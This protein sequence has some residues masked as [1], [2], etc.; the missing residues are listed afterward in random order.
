MIKDVIAD[1]LNK[2]SF[3]PQREAGEAFAPTNIALIKYWGKRDHQLNLPVT[4]SLSLTLS[5][6]GAKTK[7][8][9][10]PA[11]NKDVIFLN[12]DAV[13]EDSTFYQRTSAFLN[14]F[15]EH[16]NSHFTI[17]TQANIPVSAGLASS[18]CGMA[19]LVK[20]LDS[21][22]DWQLSTEQL[23]VLARLGSG[24][25]CRSLWPGFVEWHAGTLENGLD[26]H[27][28]PLSHQW[29]AL[30]LG[31]LMIS[32]SQKPVSTREAMKRAPMTSYLYKKWPNQVETDLNA[33]KT[34]IEEKNFTLFGTTSENNALL[35]HAIMEDST[36][37]VN[38]SLPETLQLRQK[39]WHCRSQGLPVFFTQDAGPNLKLLFLEKDQK[40]VETLF[41][42]IKIIAP[43][44]N[45]EVAIEPA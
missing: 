27:G 2:K 16:E 29:P 36:P 20:A 14:A 28:Q 33:L 30:R 17:E 37:S 21:L 19:A 40:A 35:M 9:L 1:I 22:F 13:S 12:G 24:S 43:F 8:R 23:S 32:E 42:E 5:E 31:I 25:A 26:S 34:A 6:L 18:A 39:V 3:Q 45:Q 41:P 4:N 38:Y 44:A 15:R 10:T 11:S 7:I